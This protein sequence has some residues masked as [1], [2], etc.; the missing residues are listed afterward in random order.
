M[1]SSATSD[2]A[3]RGAW[4]SFAVFAVT[5]FLSALLRAVTATLAP[6][7]SVE[8]GLGAAELGLLAGAYFLG[9]S[10]LQLPLGSALDRWGPR[11]V[12][13][14]LVVL[15]VVGCLAFAAAQSFAQMVLARM[16]IGMGVAACL[17]AP[18][19]Y[20]RQHFSH[21]IQL[22][23]NA[24]ML[25]TGSLG[26]VAST[27]PVQWL[28]PVW[29]WRGLFW[30]LGVSLMLAVPALWMGLGRDAAGADGGNG[31][32]RYADVV[33]HPEFIRLA[34]LGMALYGGLI[35]MQA[36]WIGPWLTEVCGWSPASASEGLFHVNSAMLVAFLSWGGVMPALM[37]RGVSVDALLTWGVPVSLLL[38]A[39]IV[40]GGRNAAALHW[41]VWCVSTSV[42]SLAQP[43]VALAFPTHM[44]GRA[45]SAYNLA[46]F[47]GVFLLQWGIGALVDALRGA[48]L[49]S[50]NAYRTAIGAFWLLA[51]VSYAWFLAAPRA[52]VHN[53]DNKVL[54]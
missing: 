3:M 42:V 25:M 26:M 1:L 13:V 49:E 10:L 36:L 51:L 27:L 32:A 21:G 4:A 18:L 35:A 45:L 40:F 19:T 33:R 34:P 12:E 44:A 2:P 31:R 38:L 5:Y 17:M 37:R 54:R 41:L 43:H 28:L 39:G 15:A 47:S 23:F 29:G 7:F 20:F 24:W 11:R 6:G 16:L 22:R 30:G 48:G 14:G 53:G 52:R 50:A 8:F 46:I 9:F